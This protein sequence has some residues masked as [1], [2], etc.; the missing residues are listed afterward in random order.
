MR[1]STAVVA[2]TAEAARP[3]ATVVKIALYQLSY[4]RNLARLETIHAGKAHILC[5]LTAMSTK[6]PKNDRKFMNYKGLSRSLMTIQAAL[7]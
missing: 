7:R 3:A 6:S 5:V 2:G 4:S 1:V